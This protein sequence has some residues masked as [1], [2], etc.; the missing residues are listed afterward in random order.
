MHVATENYIQKIA[1]I[2]LGKSK[3]F[4]KPPTDSE[5]EKET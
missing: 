4:R 3:N 2:T 1:K 5:K